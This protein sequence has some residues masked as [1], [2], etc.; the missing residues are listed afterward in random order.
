M[1]TQSLN[2]YQNLVQVIFSLVRILI[3]WHFLYE[4]LAKLFSPWSSA[5]YLMESQWLFSGVFHG[6]AENP[7]ALQVVDLL[8]IIGLIAVGLCLLLGLF[9]RAA[10]AVGA[11]L[12]LLY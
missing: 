11:F 4:G 7:G 8:N 12:I 9:T 5:G 1:A 6:I 10:S 2:R 3:G